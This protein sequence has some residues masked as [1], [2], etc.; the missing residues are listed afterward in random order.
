MTE[1]VDCVDELMIVLT[2]KGGVIGVGLMVTSV[3]KERGGITE[4]SV[5]GFIVEVLCEDERCRTIEIR[6]KGVGM[7]PQ[8]L[9]QNPLST[10]SRFIRIL[11]INPSLPSWTLNGDVH[12]YKILPVQGNKHQSSYHA[13]LENRKRTNT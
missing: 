13:A 7:L 1:A 9:P 12:T 11:P 5:R 10:P 3:A 4:T 8:I 6:R 2:G